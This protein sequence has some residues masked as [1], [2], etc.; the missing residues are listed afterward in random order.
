MVNS[1]LLA[2]F[3]FLPLMEGVGLMYRSEVIYYGP[4][5]LDADVFEK[6]MLNLGY[7]IERATHQGDLL[8]DLDEHPR[9][10]TVIA[11]LANSQELPALVDA[12]RRR[13]HGVNVPIFVVVD[14]ERPE[15]REEGV[16]FIPRAQRLRATISGIGEYVRSQA[17]NSLGAPL[18][19]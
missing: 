19:A 3:L 8:S 10:I 13:Q 7:W 18:Q 4:P 5:G 16:H 6:A 9:A 2:I 14:R 15:R 1:R 11:I 12:I 17:R